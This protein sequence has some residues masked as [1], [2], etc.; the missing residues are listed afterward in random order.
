MPEVEPV[1]RA[2][3]PVKLNK[4]FIVDWELRVRNWE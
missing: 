4:S 1:M 3:L 2:V